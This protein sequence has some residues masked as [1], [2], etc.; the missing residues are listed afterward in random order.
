MDAARLWVTFFSTISQ[1]NPVP[2]HGSA[3]RVWPGAIALLVPRY[4]ACAP[5]GP[6]PSFASRSPEHLWT[7]DGEAS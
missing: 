6:E 5:R 1:Q 7:T 3:E 4:L 2:R